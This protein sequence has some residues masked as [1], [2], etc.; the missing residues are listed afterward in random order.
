M[1]SSFSQERSRA[2]AGAGEGVY[3]GRSLQCEWSKC[4]SGEVLWS[5]G[6]HRDYPHVGHWINDMWCEDQWHTWAKAE[7]EMTDVTADE[8]EFLWS[9]PNLGGENRR[10]T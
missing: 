10:R 8:S 9:V 6:C 2:S 4:E 3:L 5:G 7:K 1:N